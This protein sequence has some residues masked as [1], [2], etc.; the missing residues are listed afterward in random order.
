MNL[1]EEAESLILHQFSQSPKL[2]GLV[3]GLV[4]PFKEALEHLEKLHH[5]RYIE[6][7][8]GKTLDIIGDIVEFERQNMSDEEYRIW[9]KV[10]ILLNHS[11]GTANDVLA[12]LHVLFGDTPAI[13]VDEYSPNIAMFTFF[14]YPDVPTKTLFSIIRR[15]VPITTKCQF[16]DASPGTSS[17]K[18]S[19]HSS[20]L[21]DSENQPLP[22]FQLDV[23]RF[24]ESVFA[25][26]FREEMYEQ[27]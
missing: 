22:N 23:T 14:K 9:L 11:Q 12:I 26:F 6:Q 3:R 5:G 1:L 24:D 16:V 4:T 2:N 10:V 20:V 21:K 15:A 8:Q 13:Q 27:K 7:A 17:S 25:D 19:I 18:N